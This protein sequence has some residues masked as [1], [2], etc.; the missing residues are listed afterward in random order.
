M[1]KCNFCKEEIKNKKDLLI[2]P[3]VFWVYPKFPYTAYHQS[4]FEKSKI[5]THGPINIYKDQKIGVTYFGYII[6]PLLIFAYLY[7]QN[8]SQLIFWSVVSI[9]FLLFNAWIIIKILKS[10][11]SLN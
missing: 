6:L 11:K 4:C 10:A 8:P 5:T 7:Y 1:V 9:V 2:K 3:S